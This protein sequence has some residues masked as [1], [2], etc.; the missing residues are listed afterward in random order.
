MAGDVLQNLSISDQRRFLVDVAPQSEGDQLPEFKV[1]DVIDVTCHF[2]DEHHPREDQ[3]PI[4][5]EI[6]AIDMSAYRKYRAFWCP[7]HQDFSL[8]PVVS[9]PK[10]GPADQ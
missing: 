9:T 4:K 6:T 2:A 10:Q 3:D 1:G 8:C 5:L 7:V